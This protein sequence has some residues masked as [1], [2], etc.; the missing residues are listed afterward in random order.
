MEKSSGIKPC[1]AADALA[2][3]DDP[4]IIGLILEKHKIHPSILAIKQ[5]PTKNFNSFSFSEAEVVEFSQVRKQL[6]SLDGRKSTGE[7]QIPPKLVLLAADELALSLANAINSCT[8]NYRF[9]DNEKRD[10][11]CPLDKGEA[12]RTVERNFR[13]VSILNV[14]SKIYE[15]ALK[16]QIVL[17][18]EKTLS[19]FITAYRKSYD[20]EHA[21]IRMVEEWKITLEN[22]Y[23]VGAILMDL[24]KAFDCIPHDLIKAKLHA[25]GFAENSLVLVYSYLK[26]RK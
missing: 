11:V 9:P 24:S 22:N 3:K 26:E 14:F 25:H 12:N 5:S 19:L 7:D 15:K 6:E 18:F 20:T 1:K 8:R 2:A 10:A 21:F 4:Q 17:D 16:N 13:P 23:I